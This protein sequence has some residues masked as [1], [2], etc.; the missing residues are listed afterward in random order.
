MLLAVVC[1]V[2]F[3]VASTILHF[4]SFLFVCMCKN[5]ENPKNKFENENENRPQNYFCVSCEIKKLNKQ[6]LSGNELFLE[7]I[8]FYFFHFTVRSASFGGV[9]ERDHVKS[10]NDF[11]NELVFETCLTTSRTPKRSSSLSPSSNEFYLLEEFSC[12]KLAT[13]F[14][15]ITSRHSRSLTQVNP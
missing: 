11:T 12:F 15:L 14:R 8:L 2:F 1:C 6:K 7:R 5:T 10:I 13:C 4:V 3:C 9:R